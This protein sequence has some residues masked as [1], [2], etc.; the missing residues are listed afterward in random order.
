MEIGIDVEQNYQRR[1]KIL[2]QE[3]T[4]EEETARRDMRM[5][6]ATNCEF[7]QK[8]SYTFKN[9]LYIILIILIMELVVGYFVYISISFTALDIAFVIERYL[10]SK[11]NR[12]KHYS[13]NV[14]IW[15]L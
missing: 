8:F 2:L 15:S 11:H 9:S 7:P 1:C 12:E 13:N 6:M 3:G 14:L 5:I 10:I 4:S